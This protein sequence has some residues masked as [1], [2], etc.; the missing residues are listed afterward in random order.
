MVPSEDP[1]IKQPNSF[2]DVT[3]SLCPLRVLTSLGVVGLKS[4]TFFEQS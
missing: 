1:L 2:I 3:S 4:Q